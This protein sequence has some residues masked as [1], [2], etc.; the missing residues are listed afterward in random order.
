MENSYDNRTELLLGADVLA[1]LHGVRVILFGVGG[2]GSW[3]AEGL[4]RSGVRHLTLVD[5]DRI[6]ESN[7]NR[8][9]MA[10]HRTVGQVKVEALRERLLEIDPEAQ[11]ETRQEVFSAET[12]D[13]FEL[14]AYDYIL[15][16]IDSLK[17]KGE[18]I[19]RA[20]RTPAVFFS[21]MGAALKVDPTQVRVAEFWNVR[22]CPLGAALRKKFKQNH[23]WPGHKFRCVYDEE[24]LPN[25]GGKAVSETDL[26]NKAQINGSLA[27]ITAIFGMTLAGLLIEDVYQK[28]IA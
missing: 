13:R 17:D 3:C 6:S 20:T 12:A 28:T 11:I 4:V 7:V 16:A 27:H 21:S 14:G 1:R 22:G 18:L 25:R 9:L 10:T 15:D 24:V 8:Q 2:V 26:F 5:A 19:L 23:T